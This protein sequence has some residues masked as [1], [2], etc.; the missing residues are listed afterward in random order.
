MTVARARKASRRPNSCSLPVL[1]GCSGKTTFSRFASCVTAF[2]RSLRIRA[3]VDVARPVQRA[4]GVF[5]RGETEA[6]EDGA[7]LA[8][9]RA[10]FH[11]RVDHHVADE[12]DFGGV[13]AF[14]AQ[15]V[16]G[17]ALG[18]EQVVGNLVGQD[19]VDFFRHRGGRGCGGPASTW[20]I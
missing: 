15:I 12:M 13:D 8:G 11:E 2:E 1:R 16:G 10:V 4:R 14:G 9:D 5:A 17:V 3:R 7:A 20:A 6:A 19:A 18:G